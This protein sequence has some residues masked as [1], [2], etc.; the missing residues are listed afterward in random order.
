MVFFVGIMSISILHVCVYIYIHVNI[1]LSWKGGPNETIWKCF[2]ILC[3]LV[4]LWCRIGWILLFF[5]KDQ[6]G[7]E[8][9]RT[10]TIIIVKIYIYIDTV[11]IHILYYISS[12]PET[13]RLVESWDIGCNFHFDSDMV[14]DFNTLALCPRKSFI[15]NSLSSGVA[16]VCSGFRAKRNF[17]QKQRSWLQVQH[18]QE[19]P[20]TWRHISLRICWKIHLVGFR[21][22]S[23]LSALSPASCHW[24][25]RSQ[26]VDAEQR[27]WRS[28][29]S[30]LLCSL[31]QDLSEIRKGKKDSANNKLL[32]FKQ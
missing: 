32:R 19:W 12:F 15:P 8:L 4:T 30:H 16:D 18:L 17:S 21:G 11:N 23:Q 5:H 25:Q 26:V 28:T 7:H 10:I 22:L 31:F 20:K 24:H 29:D 27:S 9:M 14:A 1:T 13:A 2:Q 3:P 6:I